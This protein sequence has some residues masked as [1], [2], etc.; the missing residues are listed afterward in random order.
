MDKRWLHCLH[1]TETLN[2]NEIRYPI[3]SITKTILSLF[4]VLLCA[5]SWCVAHICGREE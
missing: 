5:I 4:T 1:R 2:T 3:T